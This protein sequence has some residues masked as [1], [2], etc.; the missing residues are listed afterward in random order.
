MF[1]WCDGCW[2]FSCRT[3]NF[4]EEVVH[5]FEEVLF[6]MLF[7]EKAL[8]KKVPVEKQFC[9]QYLSAINE[10]CLGIRHNF[11]KALFRQQLYVPTCM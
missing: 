9:L 2:Y 1:D 10:I 4:S 5:L 3:T 6:S 11:S 8:Y 7:A